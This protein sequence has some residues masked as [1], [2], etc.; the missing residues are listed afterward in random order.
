MAD[1]RLFTRDELFAEIE[2]TWTELND[3]L[4]GLSADQ[5]TGPQDPAGWTVK[6]HVSHMA[7]W[8]DWAF[9]LMQGKPGWDGLGISEALY[10]DGD[11]DSTNAAIHALHAGKSA[12]EAR[13]DLVAAH[14][15]LMALATMLDDGGLAAPYRPRTVDDPPE[16]IIPPVSSVLYG[17]TA[18]HYAE[19]TGWFLALAGE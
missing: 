18:E 11:E 9:F 13:A 5:M 12:D 7:A 19:H 17:T 2:R 1:E 8:D 14:E 4:D 6:D 10:R 16:R 3:A 15:Q